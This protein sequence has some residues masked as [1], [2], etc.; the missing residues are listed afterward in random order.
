MKVDQAQQ[1]HPFAQIFPMLGDS[2]LGSL[3]DDIKVNGLRSPIVMHGGLILDGRNRNRACEIASVEKRF[4][5]Y[6]G[7]NPLAYVISLNLHRRH[8][9]ESQRAMAAA[10]LANMKS[11]HA[12]SQRQPHEMIDENDGAG[13]QAPCISQREAADLLNVSRAT[14]TEAKKV[15]DAGTAEEIHAVEAGVTAASTVAAGIR[16]KTPAPERKQQR[17]APLK[18]KGN[19]PSRVD[20]MRA[21]GEIWGNLRVALANITG[22]PLPADVVRIAKASDRAGFVDKKLALAIS[23]LKDFA[24][25]RAQEN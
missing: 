8:L 7:N 13:I 12:A 17:E 25:A 6:E 14:V 21:N 5:T 19:N 23:W 24:D 18:S 4:E 10:K 20:K 1:A 16:A 15:L 22:L 11:G 2:E 3:A 9:N